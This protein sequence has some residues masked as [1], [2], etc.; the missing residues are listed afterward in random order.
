MYTVY[1]DYQLA[2]IYGE[3]KILSPCDKR[4]R[5]FAYVRTFCGLQTSSEVIN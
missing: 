4:D 5:E 3:G 1:I 2:V